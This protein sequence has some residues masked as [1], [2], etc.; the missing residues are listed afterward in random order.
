VEN[1]FKPSTDERKKKMFINKFN[2]HLPFFFYSGSLSPRKNMLNLLKA[3]LLINA[4]IP[5]NIYF[6][7]GDSWR[8]N[9][10]SRFIKDNGLENRVVRLGYLS[11]EELVIAY[12]LA[13]CYL[14]PSLYEGFGLPILEAQACGCPVLT[15]TVSSCP[16][17]AGNAAL[18]V[19][20]NSP[21]SI[22]QAMMRIISEKGLRRDLQNKGFKNCARYSWR[23]AAEE[24]ILLFQN[25]VNA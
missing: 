23:R 3:F 25:V 20:P 7:G 19:D 1:N 15:S 21:K 5:H 12:S 22:A 10:V 8:D 13:E 4:E 17:I 6:T 18:L 16:E 11:E 9:D 2:V 14:Y 24:L